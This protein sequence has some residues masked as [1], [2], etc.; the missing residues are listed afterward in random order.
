MHDTSLMTLKIAKGS[1]ATFSD[2]RL[3]SCGIGRRAGNWYPVSNR[4]LQTDELATAEAKFIS[5]P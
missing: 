4:L 1:N 5:Q 3:L 2:F